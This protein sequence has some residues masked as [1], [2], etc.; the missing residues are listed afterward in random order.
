MTINKSCLLV[1]DNAHDQAVFVKALMEVSPA[2]L[3]LTAPDGVDAMYM[4]LREDFIPDYIFVE[5]SM[6]RLDGLNFLRTLKKIKN[7]KNIPVVIH[8][9]STQ[10]HKLSEIKEAGAKAIYMQRYSHVGVCNL[11]NL[12][13]TDGMI[14][15]HPN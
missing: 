3:C 1:N 2:T 4:M 5:L 13:F 12:Y 10:E 14:F 6:P 15:I 11:I 8:A 7:L 9:N